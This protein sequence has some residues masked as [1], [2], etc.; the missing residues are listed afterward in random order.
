MEAL[1]GLAVASNILQLAHLGIEG[2][3]VCKELHEKGSIDS[4]N[5]IERYSEDLKTLCK[6]LEDDLKQRRTTLAR[7]G[8][9]ALAQDVAAAAEELRVELNKLKLSKSQGMA[10]LA[11]T[12]K[13]SLKTLVKSGKLKKLQGR[14]TVQENRLQTIFAKQ[15]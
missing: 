8:I 3:A 4:D 9:N 7:D 10:R 15:Q 2:I 6:N 5:A 12:F 13:T 11:S 1:A 14:L